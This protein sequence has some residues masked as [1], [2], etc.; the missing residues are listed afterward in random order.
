MLCYAW[1]RAEEVDKLKLSGTKVD[2]LYDL[3]SLVLCNCVSKLIKKGIYKEYIPINEETCSLK[4]KINFGESLNKN[5]FRNGRAYCEFDEFSDDIVHNQIIKVTLYNILKCKT[6][7]KNIKNKVMKL[8]HYFEHIS[9]I[10]LNRAYF[11]KVKIHK[12]NRH[13]KLSIDICKLIYDDMIVDETSGNISFYYKEDEKIAYLFEEFVR[14]FYK[15]HLYNCC[16]CRE[17]IAW[18]T[19]EDPMKFLPIMQTDITIKGDNKIIIMDTKYYTKT[20]VSNMGKD[21]Y[22]STNMYQIFSY[23]KNAEAKGGLYKESTGILLY[24]QVDKE[25]DN[26]YDIQGHTLKICTINL[27]ND[28]KQIHNKLLE[29]VDDVNLKK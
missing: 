21:K 16:V 9:T 19:P 3:L 25:L 12:N 17:N 28:W 23:L 2:N 11:G 29:I 13:Y 24:P 20:L 1:N 10:K 4:G 7:D 6:V 8:Y 15:I 22:N 18:D 26:S 27:N 5:T 14:N